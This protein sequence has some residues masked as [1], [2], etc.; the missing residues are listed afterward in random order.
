M[1]QIYDMGPT[2]LTSLPKKGL[3]RIFFALENPGGF[4]RVR[5]RE[6][7]GKLPLDHRS[8]FKLY[9]YLYLVY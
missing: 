3:L 1:P 5:T 4:G 9:L 7:L 8:R 6:L 2:A